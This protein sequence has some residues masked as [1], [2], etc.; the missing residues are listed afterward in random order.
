MSV[1]KQRIVDDM[2][3]A[4]KQ[5]EKF[6]LQTIRMMLAAIKQREVDERIELDDTQVIVTLD[7]KSLSAV[8]FDNH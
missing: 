3:V 1:I 5:H 4:M 2:K 8:V 7:N 6:R